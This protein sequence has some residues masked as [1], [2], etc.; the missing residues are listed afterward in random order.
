MSYSYACADFT[1]PLL[2]HD[3]TLKLIGLLGFDGV[4]IGLFQN[5]SHIQPSMISSKAAEW[6]KA[7]KEQTD[8][9]GIAVADVFLQCD[10][11]FTPKAINHPD[12]K[13]RGDVRRRFLETVEYAVAC[14]S[15]HV[16]CLPGVRFE[17]D[18]NSLPRSYEEL[19]WRVETAKS[20]GL[21]MGFEPHLGSIADTPDK[22]LRMA[23]SVP[24]LTLTLDYTHF[25][26]IGVPDADIEPLIAHASHFHGRGAKKDALQTVLSENTIDYRRIVQSMK[27]AGYSGFIGIEYIWMEWENC[28]RSD[29]VSESLMLMKLMKEAEESYEEA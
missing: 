11:D 4:D 20:A 16:T 1:F 24:G 5:R 9:A 26:K 17:N 25:T 13:V 8:D 12:E 27:R 21:I 6:G 15:R 18:A 23:E 29:N 19:A 28:N 7:L 22:A 3:K 10:V 14:G 2:P